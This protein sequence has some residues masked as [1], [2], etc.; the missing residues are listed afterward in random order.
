MMA[1]TAAFDATGHPAMSLPCGQIDGLP[2]G[3]ML[4]G[5]RFDEGS[6]LRAAYGFEQAGYAA[7]K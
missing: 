5:R 1:N 2:V 6:I 4:V 7:L 3:M